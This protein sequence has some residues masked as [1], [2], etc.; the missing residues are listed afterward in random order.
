[1]KKLTSF[2]NESNKQD[3]SKNLLLHLDNG[4]ILEAKIN[5][6]DINESSASEQISDTV[7]NKKIQKITISQEK[8]MV[9]ES[10]EVEKT[11][12]VQE[13]EYFVVYTTIFESYSRNPINEIMNAIKDDEDVISTHTENQFGWKNQP[14]VVVLKLEST[15]AKEIKN[16]ILSKIQKALNIEWIHITKKDW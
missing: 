4:V 2:I 1:M 13:E 16:K 14:E 8:E 10:K 5:V 11:T 15:K 3:F 7:L 12:S 9:K 6:K